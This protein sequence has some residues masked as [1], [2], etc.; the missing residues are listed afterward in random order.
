MTPADTFPFAN[1]TSR[2][3][4]IDHTEAYVRGGPAGQ[5]RIGNSGPMTTFHHR[6]KTH[7]G[8]DVKQPFPGCSSGGTA[9]VR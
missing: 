4:Q 6:I 2:N 1:D 8:W 3:K 7:G 9:P 5:S